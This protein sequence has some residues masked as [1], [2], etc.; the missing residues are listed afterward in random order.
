MQVLDTNEYVD[1]SVNR[2]RQDHVVAWKVGHSAHLRGY[3][4]LDVCFEGQHR[5]GHLVG[6]TLAR[7]SGIIWI[8]I[9]EHTYCTCRV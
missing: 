8:W 1:E 7:R 4:V 3:R 6:H 5:G 2:A 9:V